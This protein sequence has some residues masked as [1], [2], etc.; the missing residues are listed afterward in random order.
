MFFS[1]KNKIPKDSI[2]ALE[3]A[4]IYVLQESYK[5]KIIMDSMSEIGKQGR[6]RIYRIISS[7]HRFI[8]NNG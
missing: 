5:V 3:K 1:K 2:V 4:L 7:P 6:N 8:A